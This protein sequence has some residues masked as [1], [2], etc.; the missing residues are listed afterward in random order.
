[1]WAG[2]Q[3]D[4]LY[5][6][7]ARQWCGRG[8]MQGRGWGAGSEVGR[9]PLASHICREGD[10]NV[11]LFH[12]GINQSKMGLRWGS[13]SSPA[14][15]VLALQIQGWWGASTGSWA[16][17]KLTSWGKSDES[18]GKPVPLPS[19][20]VVTLVPVLVSGMGDREDGC[21]PKL[22]QIEVQQSCVLAWKA[23]WKTSGSWTLDPSP[24]IQCAV[25][26]RRGAQQSTTQRPQVS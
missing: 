7:G 22:C 19:H 17:W 9:L 1:M 5:E 10:G 13:S 11:G 16:G 23:P 18:S 8:R 2:W 26:C 6:D 3:A 25:C 14:V 15:A 12:S 20:C 21:S 24:S 4:G